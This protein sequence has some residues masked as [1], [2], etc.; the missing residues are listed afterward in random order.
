MVKAM[1]AARKAARRAQEA[2]YEGLCTIYEYRDVTDEKTKLS[3]EEEVAV[4]EDQ[5][6]K[7]SFEKLNSVVQT[8]TAAVQAQGVKLFLA[9]EIVVSSNSKIVVTQNG[10]TDEYSASGIPAIYSTHQEITL[11][12]FRG[13]A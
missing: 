5:P 3:S 2:T 12:S 6:C 7:L 8:E 13:W 10:V 1:E 11:E 9:P 4:I